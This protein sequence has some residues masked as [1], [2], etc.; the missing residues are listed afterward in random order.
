MG[1]AAYNRGSAA[2][3]RGLVRRRAAGLREVCRGVMENGPCKA[4]ARCSTCRHVDHEADE[5]DRC[6]CTHPVVEVQ[7]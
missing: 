4:Y 5:G 6:R 1:A 7:R 2:I 3:R